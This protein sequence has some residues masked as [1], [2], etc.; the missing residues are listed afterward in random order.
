MV[1]GTLLSLLFLAVCGPTA[2]ADEGELAWV[3]LTYYVEA[4]VTFSGVRTGYGQTA[5]S[6]NF[7][8]G[9]RFRFDDG[10]TFVCT[11]RGRLGW[12]GWLDLWRR[13]DLARAY[14]NYALVERLP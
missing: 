9:S 7:P 3:R 12:V 5:C 4:G 10:E 13:P 2:H 14:G 1:G 6:W 8:L 11:D